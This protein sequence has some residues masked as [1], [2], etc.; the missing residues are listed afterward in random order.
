MS[1]TMSEY[2][3]ELLHDR[4]DELLATEAPDGFRIVDECLSLAH[5]LASKN[6]AYGNSALKPMPILSHLDAAERLAVRIDDK[7]NRLAQGMEDDEDVVADLA[8]YLVL[9][10]IVRNQ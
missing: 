8:G 4:L 2:D 10:M 5:M 7:I 6:A 1:G 9:L 3:R